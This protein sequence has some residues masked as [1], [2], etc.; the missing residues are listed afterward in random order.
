M[1]ACGEGVTKSALEWF[2]P[3]PVCHRGACHPH[4]GG[5][6]RQVKLGHQGVGVKFMLDEKSSLPHLIPTKKSPPPQ[7]LSK[8]NS[9][10]SH[11]DYGVP[12]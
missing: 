4:G 12:T 8:E 5:A 3:L 9:T 6:D 11:L 1:L 2:L 10:E 7:T